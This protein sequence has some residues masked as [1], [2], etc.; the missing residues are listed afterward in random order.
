[1]QERFG[2]LRPW[3]VEK[4]KGQ[5]EFLR[6]RQTKVAGFQAD[7]MVLVRELENAIPGSVACLPP[8]G[9]E[10]L[11]GLLDFGV[12]LVPDRVSAM[13]GQANQCHA[14]AAAMWDANR[15]RCR[16]ATGYGLGDDGVWRQH[17]WC[18]TMKGQ[19]NV[20]EEDSGDPKAWDVWETTVPC[21]A[22]FGMVLDHAAC[23]RFM[24]DNL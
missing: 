15:D 12:M 9:E 2:R 19:G 1:M 18:V 22:Y 6:E 3:D 10:D 5:V 4:D 24:A 7:S 8:G 21:L 17:S 14:N 23:A 16:V 11:D 13:P 20:W